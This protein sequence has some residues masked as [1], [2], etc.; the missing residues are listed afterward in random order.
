MSFHTRSTASRSL[1]ASAIRLCWRPIDRSTTT[2]CAQTPTVA[3]LASPVASTPPSCDTLEHPMLTPSRLKIP[4]PTHWSN[5]TL[6]LSPTPPP[7]VF[8]LSELRMSTSIL[9]LP[10]LVVN[11]QSTVHPSSSPAFLSSSKSCLAQALPRTCSPPEASM[12][13]L[14]TRSL[15]SACLV[16]HLEAPYVSQILS[17]L[18]VS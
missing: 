8:P 14:A 11:S 4:T 1:P 10:L 18:N 17:H 13:F 12:S 15:R 6:S 3:R 9:L 7:L 5:T 2:G 16:A